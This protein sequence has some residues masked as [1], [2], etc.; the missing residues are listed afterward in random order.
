MTLSLELVLGVHEVNHHDGHVDTTHHHDEARRVAFAASTVTD[1]CGMTTVNAEEPEHFTQVII[2]VLE[3]RAPLLCA[4]RATLGTQAC[5]SL[6]NRGTTR[7]M[8]R[9]GS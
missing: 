3:V 4:P 9:L 5:G 6:N 7:I 1:K 2:K 8:I